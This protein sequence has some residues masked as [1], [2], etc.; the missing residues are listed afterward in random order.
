MDT[1]ALEE[2]LSTGRARVTFTKV[3]GSIRVMLCTKAPNLITETNM[4]KGVGEQREHTGLLRVY[5]L[6]R[7]GWRS[8]RKDSILSWDPCAADGNAST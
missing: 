1:H 7:N 5:D 8:M 3:D 4:P 6:E 2:T